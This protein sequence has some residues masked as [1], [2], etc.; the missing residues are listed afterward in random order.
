[1]FLKDKDFKF[2]V[3]LPKKKE[4]LERLEK[5]IASLDFLDLFSDLKQQEVTLHLPKFQMEVTVSLNEPF[6]KV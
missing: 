1:M 6:E 2:V 4:S 5:Q 3:I